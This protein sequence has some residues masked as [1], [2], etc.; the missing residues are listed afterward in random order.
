[1]G[2]A[3]G[4]PAG[5]SGIARG[6]RSDHFAVFAA[7][8]ALADAGLSPGAPRPQ[9]GV[10]LGASVGGMLDTEVFLERAGREGVVEMAR[11]RHHECSGSADLVAETTGFLGFRCTLST[12]CSSGAMAI[13]TACDALESGEADILLAGGVDSLTRLT[14]FGF[15]SLL[16]VAPDG[17]RPFDADRAG[18]SLGEGGAMLV[19]EREA[20]ARERGAR[21][22]AFIAGRGATCDAHHGTAPDPE[23]A[24]IYHAMRRA[25]AA[26]GLA[27]AEVGYVNAH[28]TG[29]IDND[30]TESRA[31]RRLFGGSPPPVSSTKRVFGHTLAA[32]GAIEAAVCILALERQRIPGNP[33]LRR[34][35]P[36]V[37]F[38][39][40]RETRA[41][42]LRAALSNSMGFGGNNCA[43]LFARGE[44]GAAE[45]P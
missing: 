19:L 43:L 11:L 5:W 33:G 22:R 7:R 31:I 40:V 6:S 38:P 4:D 32:A 25:L 35:D 45:S 30:V 34:V 15:A 20:Q 23:G 18:M 8:Q 16:V 24:G 1:V 29:T 26:A 2:E 21:I 10:V 42:S 28:G 14:L 36:E 41:A 27:P 3:K 13:A 9:G 44:G 17:C 12:A 37:G 39:P